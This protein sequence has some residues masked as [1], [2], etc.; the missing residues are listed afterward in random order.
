VTLDDLIAITIPAQVAEL[1]SRH[2]G[3][4]MTNVL[5]YPVSWIHTKDELK[6]ARELL[7]R[8]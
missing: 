3:E 1:A 7:E 6:R 4:N 5:G 2:Q 8:K